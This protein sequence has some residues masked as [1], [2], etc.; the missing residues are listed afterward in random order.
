MVKSIAKGILNVFLQCCKNMR[1]GAFSVSIV[2]GWFGFGFF[3]GFCLFFVFLFGFSS[4]QW[5][6]FFFFL[7]KEGGRRL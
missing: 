5:V 6:F 3:C 7:L 2:C 4:V 1:I